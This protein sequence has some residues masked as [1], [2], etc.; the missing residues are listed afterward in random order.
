MLRYAR[1]IMQV[2]TNSFGQGNRQTAGNNALSMRWAALDEAGKVV[3]MLA[4]ATDTAGNQIRNF[5]AL[6]RNAEPWR[7][8]LA[9]HGCADMAAIMEPGITALMAINARG[10]DCTP[11][12]QALWQEFTAARAAVLALLPEN[13]EMGPQRSA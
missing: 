9:A 2:P 10:A 6:L 11:A 13:G 4:G 3:S 7:R 8:E 12:A 1:S 5:P